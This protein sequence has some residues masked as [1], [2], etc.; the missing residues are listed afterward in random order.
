MKIIRSA[1]G[2]M[3]SWGLIE[4]MQKSGIEVIGIDANPLSFGLELTKKSYVVPLANDPDFITEICKIIDKEHPDAILS[5]PEEE[6]LVLS[7]HKELLH[8]KG[9]LLLCPDHESVEIC[10]DKCKTHTFFNSIGVP[11]PIMYYF[12]NRTHHA[13]LTRIESTKFPCIVKPRFG[14]GSSDIHIARNVDE[15][16]FYER[17]VTEP[18]IQEFIRGDEYTVDVLADESGNMLSVVPR[19]RI[20]TESGISVKGKTVYDKEIIDYCVKIAKELKLFGPSCIQCIRSE[21]GLKFIEVNTRFGGGSILSI[22][23]DP[24]IILNLIKMVR[25]EETSPSKGF[26]RLTMLRYYSEVFVEKE[27]SRAGSFL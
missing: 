12:V 6:L 14:R 8:N 7:K 20:D 3:P 27:V 5:G 1:V 18:I 4:E 24:T 17:Q 9:V 25:G 22:K 13:I 19:L 10:S 16:S 11:T 21:S 2:S 15:L 23:A 26:K